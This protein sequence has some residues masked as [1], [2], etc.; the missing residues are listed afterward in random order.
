MGKWKTIAPIVISIVIAVAGSVFIYK[1]INLKT[2][3]KEV[4]KVESEAVPIVVAAVDLQWGTQLKP[5]MIKT[6]P[7]LEES[8][9]AGHFTRTGELNNRVIIAPLK[10][11][12]PVVE[13]R[14]APNSIKTGGVSAVLQSGK[15]A[16]AVKGD[17]VMGISGFV[18]PGNR[19]DVLVT[20]RDPRT[21]LDKT[22]VVL[23]NIPVLAT[24][25]QIQKNEKGEP[26]PVDVYTLEVSV[27]EAE[28][29]SLAA[30]EGRLQFALRNIT[31]AEPVLT[32]GTTISQTLASL[33]MRKPK[34]K[35]TRKWRPRNTSVT[36]E[37]IKGND[38][39]KQKVRL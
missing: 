33:S 10:K 19:V 28:K 29:L 4:V 26:A 18:N 34:K 35:T 39:K 36:V 7:F 22:K 17:K 37:V 15:R 24:G 31:D 12:E 16:V 30:S 27:E 21:K 32:K 25:T 5:E 8:L 2:A 20:L 1:W 38:L 6:A 13:H 11:G 9:P 3:P 14:L 23:E